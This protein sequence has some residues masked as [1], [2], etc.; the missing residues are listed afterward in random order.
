MLESYSKNILYPVIAF[1]VICC[2]FEW[3]PCAEW[4][5]TVKVTSFLCYPFAATSKGWLNIEF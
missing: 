3:P 2:K 4:Q 5:L 1:T